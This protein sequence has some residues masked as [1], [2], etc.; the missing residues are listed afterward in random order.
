M[1]PYLD[2]TNSKID[3]T[4]F[5]HNSCEFSKK[6]ESHHPSRATS[7]L[8][9]PDAN[10]PAKVEM[11][12]FSL[13]AWSLKPVVYW[14]RLSPR[15]DRYHCPQMGLQYAD[16]KLRSGYLE[17]YSTSADMKCQTG[18]HHLLHLS[19]KF[20]SKL[21]CDEAWGVWECYEE[22][23]QHADQSVEGMDCVTTSQLSE[24]HAPATISDWPLRSPL[25]LHGLSN[26][27][28][29]LVASWP[30][31]RGHRIIYGVCLLH[32]GC[33]WTVANI[34]NTSPVQP[35]FTGSFS[36]CGQVTLLNAR[37]DYMVLFSTWCSGSRT[38]LKYFTLMEYFTNMSYS[39]VVGRWSIP[40]NDW[41]FCFNCADN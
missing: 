6:N 13:E 35:S 31:H 34:N 2:R 27:E 24:Q 28:E 16:S 11:C 7:Q 5:G 8:R 3:F 30:A 4:G 22:M 26:K 36:C 33:F 21:T 40:T 29:I 37:C 10:P 25:W 20:M 14:C 17:G 19:P 9:Y 18:C 1:V 23:L 32:R 38:A 15:S 12:L 41:T 39:P